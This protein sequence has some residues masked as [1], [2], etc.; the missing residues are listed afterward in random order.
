LLAIVR[1]VRFVDEEAK[2]GDAA[3]LPTA[4]FSRILTDTTTAFS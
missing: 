2:C 4:P 1:M 3:V